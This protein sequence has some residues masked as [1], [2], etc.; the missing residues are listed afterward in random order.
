MA[1]SDGAQSIVETMSRFPRTGRVQEHACVALRY[2]AAS[3]AAQR[4]QITQASGVEALVRAVT[5]HSKDSGVVQAGF[6]VLA[7]LSIGTPMPYFVSF[8]HALASF[9]S[10]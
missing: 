2:L 6:A 7:Y 4:V 10:R 5:T 9:P 8:V 1:V 3:G